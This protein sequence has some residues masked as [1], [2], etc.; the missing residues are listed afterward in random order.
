MLG[1]RTAHL[2]I[3]CIRVIKKKLWMFWNVNSSPLMVFHLFHHCIIT[4][5]LRKTYDAKFCITA[6]LYSFRFPPSISSIKLVTAIHSLW[7][8]MVAVYPSTVWNLKEK[9]AFLSQSCFSL[10]YFQP[11]NLIGDTVSPY[12]TDYILNDQTIKTVCPVPFNLNMLFCGMKNF[13]Q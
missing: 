4:A 3:L 12:Y 13:G 9:N 6:A 5:V 7:L 2:I 10:K 11:Q 8:R 1:T